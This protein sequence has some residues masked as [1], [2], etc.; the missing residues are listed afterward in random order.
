[1]YRELQKHERRVKR[2]KKL[3]KKDRSRDTRLVSS[4]GRIVIRRKAA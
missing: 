3:E 1:M 2:S 4:A